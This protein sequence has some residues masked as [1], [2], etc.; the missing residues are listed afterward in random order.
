M[1]QSWGIQRFFQGQPAIRR[2]SSAGSL[3]GIIR[4]I[5]SGV[6][7]SVSRTASIVRTASRYTIAEELLPRTT[8]RC[9]A[10][11]R[12][13]DVVFQSAGDQGHPSPQGAEGQITVSCL[14][15]HIPH[16]GLLSYKLSQE[17]LLG[18]ITWR[19]SSSHRP[20]V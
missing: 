6:G 9:A 2:K 8:S 4:R 19:Q 17:P 18:K 11:G 15:A 3:T 16:L 7:V 14:S 10:C 5:S 1:P 12:Q 13:R 20:S